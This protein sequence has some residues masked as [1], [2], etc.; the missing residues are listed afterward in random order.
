[1]NKTTVILLKGVP[2]SGKS[3]WASEEINKDPLNTIRINRDAIR[4]MINN[5]NYSSG[6]EKL[7][8]LTRDKML[9]EALKNNYKTIIID[10]TN[11]DNRNFNGLLKVIRNANVPCEVVEKL[12]YIDL[13]EAIARDAKRTGS[14]KVGEEVV[15]R[16]W[17][18]AGGASFAQ[19]API[20]ITITPKTYPALNMDK[21][22][23][24]AVIF[25]L[26][27]TMCDISHRDPYNAAKCFYDKPNEH[28]VELCKLFHSTGHKIFFFS[29][30]D[31]C[32][33]KSTRKW[34]D[35]YFGLSYELRMRETGN[36]EDD[37]DLKERFFMSNIEKQYHCKAWVDDRLRVCRFIYE[38]KLPLFRVGCPDADF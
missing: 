27:G 26:D 32:N 30:R 11:L 25:D 35:K 2:A 21:S 37:R 29:G 31:D 6:I 1:M 4:Q 16:F 12:F 22:L 14:A 5:Y 10:E 7:V 20:S 18:K 28:V 34:L 9:F 17:K 13:D 24:A 38:A 36:K 33:E 8:K 19:A 15:K 23:P 3:T